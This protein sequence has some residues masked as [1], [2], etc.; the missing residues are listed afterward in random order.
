MFICGKS[1]EVEGQYCFVDHEWRGGVWCSAMG[2]LI[3]VGSQESVFVMVLI[4]GVRMTTTFRLDLVK[5][6]ISDDQIISSKV[7][8]GLENLVEPSAS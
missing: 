4:T 7:T 6:S 8:S 2:A 5:C 3:V 1:I